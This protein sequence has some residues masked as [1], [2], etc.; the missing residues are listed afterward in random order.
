MKYI[1]VDEARLQ[2]GAPRELISDDDIENYINIVEPQVERYMNTVFTPTQEIEN[3]WPREMPTLQT[4]KN[5]LL[6]VRDFR[7][8]NDSINTKNLEVYEESGIVRLGNNA[9]FSDFNN[10]N[11]ATIKYLYG[12]V[13]EDDISSDLEEEVDSGNDI[14]ITTSDDI[15]SDLEEGDYVRIQG[16]DGNRE[17]SRINSISGTDITLDKLVLGHESDSRVVKLKTPEYIKRLIMAETAI[18]I[19]VYAIGSTYT[20]NTGYSIGEL[21]IQKGVPYTHWETNLQKNQEIRNSIMTSVR[22]RP[23]I[24]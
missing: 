4:R 10:K 18:A 9:P 22:V 14:T 23:A 7:F 15:S 21:S 13:E 16:M 2:S 1:T 24:L 11:K 17:I 12:L 19:A 3:I 8:D 20:F 6:T 5:P